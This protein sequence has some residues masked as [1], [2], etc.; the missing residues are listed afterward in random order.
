MQ[1]FS[2]SDKVALVILT[3]AYHSTDD[4]DGEIKKLVIV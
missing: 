3:N 4:F 2:A 1:E